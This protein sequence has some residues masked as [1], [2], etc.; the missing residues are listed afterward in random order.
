METNYLATV[1]AA[2]SVFMLGWVWYH[3]KTFGT[4]WMK[5]NGFTEE[6]LAKGNMLKIFGFALLF[7][8]MLSFFMPM[9][10]I[11]QVGAA[12]L[13]GG[14]INNAELQEILKNHANDFRS[15][16]HGALHGF[17]TALFLVLPVFGTN[18]LFERRS[19]K[20]IFIHVGY[21]LV[22]FTIMGA[23]ICGWK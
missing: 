23:I 11:H 16:E 13:F 2:I 9:F 8:F 6:G 3:P 17:I 10:T 4:A 20:Y 5:E 7:A 15:F 12:Q 18:A 19:W 21:W 1:V 22:G 14:D